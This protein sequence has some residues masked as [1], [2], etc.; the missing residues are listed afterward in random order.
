MFMNIISKFKNRIGE[1]W[2]YS[3]LLFIACRLGD[4]IQAFIG[5]WLVPKY[6]GS[7]ELGAI[8]PLQQLCTLFATPIMAMSIVF[9]KYVTT[10]ATRGEYG[11]LKSFVYDVLCISAAVFPIC[12]VIA[13]WVLP[14]FYVRLN[15]VSGLLTILILMS[16]LTSNLWQLV[17][18]VLQGLKKFRVIT[19]ISV[20]GSPIRL[21]TLLVAMPVRAL[22]GYILGQATPPAT[23]I[24]IALI[25]IRN[26][27]K[28]IKA[29]TSW[30]KDLP[31]IIRYLVP[32]LIFYVLSNLISSVTLTVYRQR[33]PEV[34]S[35]A[36]YLLSRFA[37]ISTY[38][39]MSMGVILFPLAAEAYDKGRED[40][41]ALRKTLIVT[42]ITTTLLAVVFKIFAPFILGLTETWSIY[43]PY[44][45]LL[46]IMSVTMGTVAIIG[47]VLAYEM[48]CRRYGFMF[49]SL[50]MN[51]LWCVFLLTF[52]GYE[53]FRGILPHS[54]VEWMA[55]TKM[56]TLEKFTWAQLIVTLAQL[57]IIP[58][59][60]NL[61]Y[62]R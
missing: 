33:L 13:Y 37:E 52:T 26:N 41:S 10:Y 6:V 9:S 21:I 58:F 14:Y 5:I 62:L 7:R 39:G 45:D 30:R 49:F 35:G 3:L 1:F 44:A 47:S 29:D 57:P 25:A 15:V 22:S 17:H 43:M 36:Y 38:V 8:L 23:S 31:Q 27:L 61:T 24:V 46:S 12:I 20:I 54:V 53:F 2:W 18:S 48:A 40:S 11:K 51:A 28:T 32:I 34:E 4:V 50:A 60:R 16:G 56:A 19:I 42:T 59:R 55:L